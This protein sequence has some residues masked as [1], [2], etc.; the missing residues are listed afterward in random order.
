M[1]KNQDLIKVQRNFANASDVT[2]ADIENFRQ[3]I[4]ED[5]DRRLYAIVTLLAYSGL[6][7]SE[8]LNIKLDDMSLESKELIVRK[9]K[10][11]NR[12]LYISTQR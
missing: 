4:L 6:R 1:T 12:E 2:K 9:G 8:A 7:I 5:G 10:G 3:G 11:E